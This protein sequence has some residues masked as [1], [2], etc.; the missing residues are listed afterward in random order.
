[1]KKNTG[2]FSVSAT[3][4]ACGFLASF[5]ATPVAAQDAVLPVPD[6]TRW[7]G[8]GQATGVVSGN[9]FNINQT[10]QNVSLNWQSFDIGKDATVNFLQPS[11]DAVALN[12]IFQADPVSIRGALNANGEVYL[13]SQNGIIF[14]K[15]A[16]VNVRG[17]VA[18]TLNITP[19]AEEFGLT[20]ALEFN[21]PA[22]EAALDPEGNLASKDISVLNGARITT[23]NGGRVFMFAPNVTNEG[24]INTPDG[25]TALAA[26]QKIYLTATDPSIRGLVVEVDQGGTVTHGSTETAGTAA[27]ASIRA[28]H[29]NVTLVGLAVNQLGRI[30]ASTAVRSGGSIRLMARESVV[31]GEGT[32]GYHG[33]TV[34]FG[35]GSITEAN[36]DLADKELTLDANEQPKGRIQAAGHEI[37]LR[38]DSVVSAKSG[39][40]SFVASP[41]GAVTSE[42]SADSRVY[43]ED[44]S[45]IDVSGEW[46]DLPAE[47]NLLT[48]R[49]QGAE[50][51]DSPVQR[52]SALRGQVVTVDV[53]RRGTTADGRSWI[54]TPLA[55]LNEAAQ[56]VR[57][58]VAERNTTGGSVNFDARG[59]VI[60]APGSTI[61][62][63]G[64]GVRYADGA[65]QTTML[66]R[67]GVITD[68]A[69]ADPNIAYDGIFGSAEKVHARWGVIE[70]YQTAFLNGTATDTKPGA[71]FEGRDAG[72]VQINSA[73]AILDGAMLGSTQRGEFQRS[74]TTTFTGSQRPLDQV[75]RGARLVL[76]SA[77]AVGQE[78][79]D[80]RLTNAT[81]GIEPVIPN[82]T[83]FDPLH[84]PVPELAASVTVPVT[85]FGEGRFSS[86]EVYA[87]RD[88]ELPED[89]N[90][91]LGPGGSVSFTAGSIDMNG[92]IIARGGAVSLLARQTDDREYLGGRISL[93]ED[94]SIDVSGLWTND[95]RAPEPPPSPYDRILIDGG[96]IRIEARQQQELVGG[97]SLAE[98]SRLNADGGAWVNGAA[99]VAAGRGGSISLLTRRGVDLKPVELT[100]DGEISAWGL[101]NGGSLTVQSSDVCLA[102]ELCAGMAPG[103]TAWFTPDYLADAGFRSYSFISD[104]GSLTIPEGTRLE[105]RQRNRLLDLDFLDHAD[106]ADLADFT[107]IGM[108]TDQQRKPVDLSLGVRVRFVSGVPMFDEDLQR[109]GFLSVGTGSSITAEPGARIDLA[110]DTRLFVDGSISAP[111]GTIS[112][113]LNSA[114]IGGNFGEFT[115]SQTLWLGEHAQLLAAGTSR[116]LTDGFGR[117]TG[118]V[119]A[120]GTVRLDARSG[121]LIAESGSRIDVS[122][123][124]AELDILQAGGPHQ[125]AAPQATTVSADAGSIV[126]KSAEGI[127]FAGSLHADAAAEGARAGSLTVEMNAGDRNDDAS[128]TE[129]TAE[130]LGLSVT[131]RTVVVSNENM[132]DAIG[133]LDFGAPVDAR[134]NALAVIDPDLVTDG[135]FG[136]VTLRAVNLQRTEEPAAGRIRFEGDVALSATRRLTI[137]AA[138]IESNGG[139]ATVHAPYVA[140]GNHDV[141]TPAATAVPDFVAR[142]GV[143][144]VSADLIDLVGNTRLLGIRSAEFTSAGD[145]RLRGSHIIGRTDISGSLESTGDLEFVARQI[146]APTLNQFTVAVRDNPE[147][148]IAIES[149][150]APTPVL[151][152]GSRLTFDAADIEQGG[153]IKAPLGEIVFNASNSLTLAPGSVTST[154]LEN[155]VVPFGRVEVGSDWVYS[156]DATGT[157]TLRL[158]YTEQANRDADEF[159]SQHVRLNAPEITLAEGSVLDQ[160][161]GGDLLAYEFQSGLSGTTDVL[162]PAAAPRNYALVPFLDSDYA[163]IDPQESLRFGL[164]PGESVELLSD[165]PGLPGGRYALLPAR[166]ALL[167]GAFLVTSVSGYSDLAPGAV[168]PYAQGGSVIS[169]RRVFADGLEGDSRTSGFVIRKQADIAKLAQYDTFLAN[170]FAAG[171]SGAP[172]PRDGGSTQINAETSLELGGS[173]R[174]AGAT[175]G[176]GATVEI[177]GDRLA[178][179]A[180]R[181]SHTADEDSLLLDAAGLNGLGA[182]SL[183]LG[184]TREHGEDGVILEVTAQQVEIDSGT[185]LEAPEIILAATDTVRVEEG[186]EI[187]GGGSGGIAPEPFTVEGDGALLRVAAGEQVEFL[188]A[189]AEG[190]QGTLLVEAGAVVGATGATLL[191]G[192]QDLRFEG[193]L[194]MDDGSLFVDASRINLG[195]SAAPTEGFTL[196]AEEFAALG[197]DD[198]RLVGREG[199]EIHE[200]MDVSVARL[201]LQAPVV[202]GHLAD[203]ER[204]R[205]QAEEFVLS[206]P[207]AV[208]DGDPVV[209]GAGALEIHA[210]RIDLGVGEYSIEGFANVALQADDTLSGRAATEGL[211]VPASGRLNV[212]GNL[213]LIAGRISGESSSELA[214]I[215]TGD[216][217]IGAGADAPAPA[218]KPDLGARLSITGQ[219]VEHAGRI[220]LRSGSLALRATGAAADDGVTLREGSSI[221]VSGSVEH[222]ADKDVFARAGDVSLRADHGDVVV[223]ADST[224]DL[225]A[226]DEGGNAGSLS[227]AA[228]EGVARLEGNIRATASQRVASGSFDLDVHSLESFSTLNTV[229]EGAGF[230]ASREV[231]VRTG[232]IAVR[233]D[234]VV[235]AGHVSLTADAGGIAVVGSIDASGEKAGSIELNAGN[236]VVVQAGAEL[237]A[238]ATGE[239]NRGGDVALRSVDGGVRV[240]AG[241][242]MDVSAAARP[243]ETDAAATLDRGGRIGIRVTRDAALTLTDADAG[244]NQLQLAGEITGARRIDAEAYAR[245]VETDG[246]LD[247]FDTSTAGNPR[248]D[249]AAAFV[250]THGNGIRTALLPASLRGSLHLLPGVEIVTDELTPDLRLSSTWDLSQWRFN[251]EAGVL[252][253]RAL[254]NLTFDGSLSDGFNGTADLTSNAVPQLRTDDS[255]SYRL[256]A[257]AD[258]GSADLM[259]TGHEAIG[260]LSIAAGRIGGGTARPRP[261]AIRTGT[262]S[263]ELASAGDV[264][265]G[266]RASIIYT[267]GRDL[268][269]GFRLGAGRGTLENRPYPL[270]GGDISI[271]AAGTVRG[272]SPEGSAD[273][274][275]FGNQLIN[276]WLYRQGASD[277]VATGPARRATGWTVAFDR[278]EQGVGALGGGNVSVTAGGGLDNLSIS[279][280]SIG[281]QVGGTAVADSEVE[282]HG[283]GD[284]TVRAGGDIAGGVF[285]VGRGDADIRSDGSV[286]GGRPLS[287]TDPTLLHTMLAVGE[288]SIHVDARG[289]LE[290]ESIVNPTLL[291]QNP[292]QRNTILS[293]NS[294][295]STYGTDS[296]VAL[297]SLAG[298]AT[299]FNNVLGVTSSNVFGLTFTTADTSGKEELALVIYPPELQVAALRGDIRVNEGFTLYP[300]AEG[301]LQLLADGNVFLAGNIS[302]SDANV[303]LLP[304][305]AA[306]APMFRKFD[307]LD[308]VTR[309][310]SPEPIHARLESGDPAR[311]VARDGD[312]ERVGAN[313]GVFI[314]KE[315]LF[316][317]GRD[318]LNLNAVIQ[319]VNADDISEIRAGRDIEY[320]SLR[321]VQGSIVPSDGGIDIQGPGRLLVQAGRDIDLG[322]S[323]GISSLGDTANLA[324]ANDGADVILFGGLNGHAPDVAAFAAKYKVEADLY[325]VI[326]AFYGILRSA[327]RRN[328]AL[329]NEQRSY[330]DAFE[331]IKILFPGTDYSGSMDMFFS[332]VYTLDGGDIDVLMPGGGVNVGLAAP[333]SSFGI[334][335]PASELGMVAQGLGTVR[336]FLDQDFEVNE[337]RV[338]AAD[339]GDIMVWSSN[340]DIDAGRGAKTSISAP[341]PVINFNPD[342]GAVTVSFPPALTG[343]GI[344]TLTSTPGRAFG[345]VD[346]F[347]PRG[348]VDASEAG[349]ETLGNLTI[350]A[351]EVLGTQNIKVGGVSTGVPVDTGGLAASL[352]SVSSVSNSAAAAS[353]DV[354][355]AAEKSSQAPIADSAMSFLEVFV[356]GFGEGVCDAKD[357]ACLERQ[358]KSQ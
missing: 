187:R 53:R 62:V 280:P 329:P 263:I 77:T 239:G 179:I 177:T 171:F 76:G 283:G 253:V 79:P 87:N 233:A 37:F 324:L 70:E 307:V 204:V 308:P 349:I 246:E 326:D 228:A 347:T 72:A 111:A 247:G 2:A 89:I 299:L 183:I 57:R 357:Q 354:A 12:R 208:D 267:A 44:G 94:A 186:A 318:L 285:F 50:L 182:A 88:I 115:P 345:S 278:F 126:L 218:A 170:K 105:L 134:H 143:L 272:V 137:D 165:L 327:G 120:G 219:S 108:L 125:A 140:V 4:A 148:R 274:A 160:S 325:K 216:V 220:E 222:F 231:R 139:V 127:L 96:S 42:V 157:N 13:L 119:F 229:L 356:M 224:L 266:N 28:D 64:G 1:M 353:T 270:Q 259:T 74:P 117:R 80:F 59:D 241:S 248:F 351:V 328:A 83:A 293:R 214:I 251:G 319:N 226:P 284:L 335:K 71:Y 348:V 273:L 84:D 180:D 193:E 243:N 169:G 150:G 136:D 23:P 78:F 122:G 18:T 333:P 306:P 151:S 282:V 35:A 82:I 163:P 56:G 181:E 207:A 65:V 10:S 168:L 66:V 234:D 92:Q 30:S 265:L 31:S 296:S 249:E 300:S 174:A 337:S 153:V 20:R 110:S 252:T 69:N 63:S 176:R 258:A 264:T 133:D 48:V 6:V 203:G 167:P 47:R 36:P 217:R 40:V 201:E 281:V 38:S 135:G 298:D 255:W 26:G 141:V 131:A 54:G 99:R 225:S 287:E 311:F 46:V 9:T 98:G 235:R 342:T 19:A 112:L 261:V 75:P 106:R 199:V 81:F 16:Q 339:G 330:A 314:G 286:V 331:A 197:V 304:T 149:N 240:L 159:P 147:G 211:D 323:R 302:L 97:L 154:S 305:P 3:G 340:G 67:Q 260:A 254:G 194:D 17:L 320:A 341:P 142:G 210:D 7:V 238:N 14:D 332:R 25:Q 5:V 123:A 268:D 198:L 191:S 312:I 303:E 288:G 113:T 161:G 93:G 90:L 223:A 230:G 21:T 262:G 107:A 178:V 245:Y 301:D 55:D 101:E 27:A 215:A 114:I 350:A 195:E 202:T 109:A 244:N 118:E 8:T 173:I 166:Y 236:D 146:Y 352:A 172:L 185:T 316:S 206:N 86:L 49:L 130:E 162:D 212:D 60:L 138:G 45:R 132:Q 104:G 73:R 58:S 232:D 279:I 11:A 145:I 121:Y 15:T 91:D 310:Y 41:T 43:M 336:A 271:E 290:L 200:A 175:G 315:T 33:G 321:N 275:S 129:V 116:V 184:G 52:D 164:K 209:A 292:N 221:D 276:S 61:D 346:L 205:V 334:T 39:E 192:A 250:D 100:I 294:F 355:A 358:K 196:S 256:V 344:R 24:S 289:R 68:I 309:V 190:L 237:L 32:S 295:F 189:E 291:P 155:Q 152:A 322:A 29:G 188:R 85:L 22:F 277:D 297:T 158:V 124:S 257:G 51:R 144:E 338:F 95:V 103:S 227:I 102:A 313:T 34:T 317:A 156:V 242:T 128:R 213:D 343:S 269:L